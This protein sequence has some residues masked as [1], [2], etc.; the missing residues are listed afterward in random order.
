VYACVFVIRYDPNKSRIRLIELFRLC[1]A[2]V[3][4]RN[5]KLDCLVSKSTLKDSMNSL[6]DVVD[7]D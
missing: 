7:E 4:A 3:S 1:F 6:E 2:A 5:N